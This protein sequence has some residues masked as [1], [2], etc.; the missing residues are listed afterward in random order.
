MMPSRDPQQLEKLTGFA[1]RLAV[2]IVAVFVV[3]GALYLSV[4]LAGPLATILY[5]FLFVMALTLMPLIINLMGNAMPGSAMLGRG[6]MILGAFAFDHLY[7]VDRGTQWELCPGE[8]DRVYIDD[9]WHNITGGLD[10][11]SVLAWRPFGILRYKDDDTLTQVRVDEKALKTRGPRASTDGG[12]LERGNYQQAPKDPV[13]GI[14]GT[15]LVDLKRV[16]SRGVRKIGDIEIIETAEEIIERGQ[17]NDSRLGLDNPTVTFFGALVF[18][19][20]TGFAYVY[21]MG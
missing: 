7:L 8:E 2:L 12:E 15:W 5:A 21:M 19:V 3:S 18:G 14:D 9:E 11:K 1:K 17:V 6:H 20:V 10:K 16:Y 13:S 4:R